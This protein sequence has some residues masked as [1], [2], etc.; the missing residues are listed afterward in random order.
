MLIIIMV[1][2]VSKAINNMKICFYSMYK[3]GLMMT[4]LFMVFVVHVASEKYIS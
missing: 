1:N 3:N 2:N 4:G